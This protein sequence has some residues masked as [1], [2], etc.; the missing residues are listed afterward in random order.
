MN[1]PIKVKPILLTGCVQFGT[2]WAGKI[3][4]FAPNVAMLYE[5]FHPE[6]HPGMCTA[7]FPFHFYYINQDETKEYYSVVCNTMSFKYDSR[8]EIAERNSLKDI[9][10]MLLKHLPYYFFH[11][12]KKSRPLFKAPYAF[13][14]TEWLFE[15]FESQ[16]IILMRHPAAFVSSLMKYSRWNRHSFA[17]SLINQ[18]QLIA[19]FNLNECYDDLCF[20]AERKKQVGGLTNHEVILKRAIVLWSIFAKTFL[21]YQKKYTNWIFIRH[22][23]LS[24]NPVKEFKELYHKLN[25]EFTDSVEKKY[26]NIQ[27]I[28]I[29][30][31]IS[32][33]IY[34]EKA[35]LILHNGKKDLKQRK[36]NI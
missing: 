14:S 17:N 21:Y 4:N 15:N 3:I 11:Q 34:Y 1:L 33:A 5:P 25:I 24:L 31:I 10:R 16:N 2:T 9:G 6:H 8:N 7:K 19:N 29:K 12:L 26:E 22:E 13:F 28:I 20:F 23:D 18:K 35:K 27:L 30:L 32:L 36:F